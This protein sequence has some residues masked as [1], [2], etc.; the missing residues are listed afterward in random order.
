M[1]A[2][3]SVGSDPA[4]GASGQGLDF[5][6]LYENLFVVRR[7]GVARGDAGKISVAGARRGWRGRSE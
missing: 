5:E 2:Q 6:E 4:T 7:S 3:T 1:T